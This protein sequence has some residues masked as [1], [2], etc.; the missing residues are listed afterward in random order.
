MAESL[1]EYEDVANHLR[2]SWKTVR[3]WAS[4]GRL[5][6]VKVGVQNRFDPEAIRSAALAGELPYPE[7]LGR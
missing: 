7:P 3:R 6:V 1:W 5:P 2:I 4:E